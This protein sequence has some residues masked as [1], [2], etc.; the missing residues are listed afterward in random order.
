MADKLEKRLID[1]ANLLAEYAAKKMPDGYEYRLIVSRDESRT[2]L[3]DSEGDE[4]PYEL[5]CDGYSDLS[6]ACDHAKDIEFH[7]KHPNFD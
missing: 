2:E 4:I 5:G 3:I 1:A 6:A 7:A